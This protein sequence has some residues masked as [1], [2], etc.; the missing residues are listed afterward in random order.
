MCMTGHILE[1]REYFP[2]S[3]LEVGEYFPTCSCF[4]HSMKSGTFGLSHYILSKSNFTWKV[5]N[6]SNRK[7]SQMYI[8]TLPDSVLPL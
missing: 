5:Q 2:T 8:H 4:V 1:F 6:D 3:L 7:Q